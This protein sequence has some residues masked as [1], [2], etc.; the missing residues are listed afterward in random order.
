MQVAVQRAPEIN[1]AT[2]NDG[3]RAETQNSQFAQSFQKMVEQEGKQVVNTNQTEQTNVDKDGRGQGGGK[4]GKGKKR[5][6]QDKDEKGK[7][8]QNRGLLDIR[9]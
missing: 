7:G 8:G 1:R 2:N 5:P 4:D 6:G 3:S 9:I